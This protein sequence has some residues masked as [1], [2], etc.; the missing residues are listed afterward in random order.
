[1][2]SETEF[3]LSIETIQKAVSNGNS[4]RAK[5][6]YHDLLRRYPGN[7]KIRQFEAFFTAAED[8]SA[9]INAKPHTSAAEPQQP[10]HSDADILELMLREN[11]SLNPVFP[12]QLR[13]I[14]PN[15]L[16]V[17]RKYSCDEWIKIDLS[18]TGITCIPQNA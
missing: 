6:I 14:T 16:C 2:P 12:N 9:Y 11:N 3:N 4:D 7:K 17:M 1:M 18:N 5:I 10:E 8:K 13:E 15:V